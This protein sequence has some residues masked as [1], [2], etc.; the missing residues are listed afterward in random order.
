MSVAQTGQTVT[1]Q[2][3]RQCMTC[4]PDSAGH[5]SRTRGW[6]DA[7]FRGSLCAA[8]FTAVCVSV[9]VCCVMEQVRN[10][11]TDGNSGISRKLHLLFEFRFD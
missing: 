9:P 11:F 6:V 4:Q 1:E 3:D 10:Q 2:F 8:T 7:I 5:G